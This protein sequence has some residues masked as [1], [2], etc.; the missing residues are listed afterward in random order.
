MRAALVVLRV[1]SGLLF[2]MTGILKFAQHSAAIASFTHWQIPAPAAAV[3]IIGAL[4]LVC[5]AL[6]VFGVLTRAV[7][8][9]LAVDMAAAIATAGRIDGGVHLV[10]APILLIVCVAIAWYAG[11]TPAVTPARPPGVQ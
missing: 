4:E 11:R 5:G 3:T 10:L 6:L 8:I 9:V 7:A 1:L 2:I